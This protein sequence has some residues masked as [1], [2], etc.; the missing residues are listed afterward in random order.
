VTDAAA[1]V[2]VPFLGFLATTQPRAAPVVLAPA[3]GADIET[4]EA[5][6]LRLLALARLGL[7]MTTY[8]HGHA[9][10]GQPAKDATPCPTVRERARDGI[11]LVGSHGVAFLVKMLR[12]SPLD[13]PSHDRRQRQEMT[14][15]IA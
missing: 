15:Q 6:A 1:L 4:A 11:E 2:L 5:I 10:G 7:G 13:M 14:R 9:K 8:N 12:L 3:R